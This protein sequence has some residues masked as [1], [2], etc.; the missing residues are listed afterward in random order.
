MTKMPNPEDLYFMRAIVQ[1]RGG[2]RDE[3]LEEIVRGLLVTEDEAQVRRSVAALAR[4]QSL[5][6]A[7]AWLFL[8]YGAIRSRSR[9]D[10]DMERRF[11]AAARKVAPGE[12]CVSARL[13]RL[14]E[15]DAEEEA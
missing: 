11:L 12:R 5:K 2:S 3:S 15:M 4:L 7:K 13:R 9:D 6:E 10:R 14:E 8:A 1:L